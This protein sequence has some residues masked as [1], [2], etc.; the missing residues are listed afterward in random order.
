MDIVK[1]GRSSIVVSV[2]KISI[3]RLFWLIVGSRGGRGDLGVGPG[4]I[5]SVDNDGWANGKACSPP[6]SY[7]VAGKPEA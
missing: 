7:D 5:I 3:M 1:T 2:C 4:W 6:R